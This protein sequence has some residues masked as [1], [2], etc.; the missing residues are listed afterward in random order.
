MKLKIKDA[1]IYKQI[2][3]LPTMNSIITIAKDKGC[4]V[5][6]DI[7][8]VGGNS[9]YVH[10]LNNVVEQC[11]TTTIIDNI[12][13][14]LSIIVYIAISIISVITNL[15]LSWDVF[16]SIIFNEISTNVLADIIY[17]VVILIFL[18]YMRMYL[19]SSGVVSSY[20]KYKN[21]Y[22]SAK[23]LLTIQ[24]LMVIFHKALCIVSIMLM[25]YNLIK[26]GFGLQILFNMQ[27]VVA[28]YTAT[29]VCKNICVLIS[30]SPMKIQQYM[31]ENINKKMLRVLYYL[32][33]GIKS[34]DY[35]RVYIGMD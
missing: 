18:L 24:G 4:D 30:P 17:L 6:G 26:Y 2:L 35:V 22:T 23:S 25:V 12:I 10:M 1:I 32:C 34:S 15:Y 29:I 19:T 21:P 8:H 33:Y 7:V 28:L 5:D 14:I 3:D 13:H 9:Y 31:P 27:Y 20:I 11:Y 16:Y